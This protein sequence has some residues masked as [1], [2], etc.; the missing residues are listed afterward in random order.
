[1]RNIKLLIVFLL[2]SVINCSAQSIWKTL[3][4]VTYK[5]RYD[6]ILK[7]EVDYPVFSEAIKSKE[8]KVVE[9]KGYMVPLEEY[10]GH[11]FFVLS[12]LPYNICFFCGAAGPETVMEVYTESEIEYSDKP[13]IVKG[14]LKLNDN[15]YD[16]LMYML[17][18]AEQIEP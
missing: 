5:T 18:N 3:A 15:N 8:G 16:H 7:Y 13:I 11:N 6:E 14:V 1:M 2:I 12:A 9:V 10:R 17:E 4:N